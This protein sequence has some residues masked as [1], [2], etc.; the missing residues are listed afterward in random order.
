M[1]VPLVNIGKIMSFTSD[2]ASKMSRR[3]IGSPPANKEKLMPI[4][5]ASVKM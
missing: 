2:T 5:A 1:S 3:I 4:S